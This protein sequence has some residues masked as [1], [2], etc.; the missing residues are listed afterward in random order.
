MTAA[1][2]KYSVCYVMFKHSMCF[3]PG[4][5]ADQEVKVFQL[6]KL[7]EFFLVSE[8]SKHCHFTLQNFW[9]VH[10]V[11]IVT[12]IFQLLVTYSPYY[13]TP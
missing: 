13:G 10:V 6:K 5:K 2:R 4:K 7:I 3:A 8:V 9:P 12:H 11:C 1:V